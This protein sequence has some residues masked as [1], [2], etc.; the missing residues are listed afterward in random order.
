MN[1]GQTILTIGAFVLLTTI[2][3]GLY[4]SLGNVGSDISSGQDGI[5]A[6]TIATSY[7]ESVNRLAFDQISDTSDAALASPLLLTYP[8]GREAGE[9]SLADFNDFDD[10][11]GYSEVKIAGGSGR[12]YRTIFTVSYVNETDVS[13]IVANRTYVKRLDMKTWRISPPALRD[14]I[15]DTLSTSLVLGYF[16][17]D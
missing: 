17:F 14:E 15:I 11:N 7:C 3:Q 9:D 16:H 4:N 6:T 12:A 1:T 2:L 5:L 13:T 8:C 10:L